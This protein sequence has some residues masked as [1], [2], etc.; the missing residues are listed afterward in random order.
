MF[1]RRL[2][3]FLLLIALGALRGNAQTTTPPNRHA[4]FSIGGNIRDNGN[5]RAMDNVLVS[6]KQLTGPTVPLPI[7]AAMAISS[8]MD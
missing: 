3:V 8:S 7:P 2:P 5:Q 4:V 1:F 6:L